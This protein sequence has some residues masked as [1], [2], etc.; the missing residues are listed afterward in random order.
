MTKPTAYDMLRAVVDPLRLAVAGAAVAGPVSIDAVARETGASKKEVARAVGDLRAVGILDEDGMVDRDALRTIG[1]ELP[2][3]PGA[4]G[5]PIDGPWTPEEAQMLG[6][7]FDG[8]RLVELPQ[9]RTKRR[10]VLEHITQR[11]EP[12]RRYPE[13][14]V[15]FMIQL[16]YPD[17]AAIRRY[18]VDEGFLD[19]ADGAYWRIGGRYDVAA[20][21]TPAEPEAGPHVLA[22]SIDG[23]ELRPWDWHMIDSLVAA[24]NDPRINRYMGDAFPHP[25]THD[26][27]ESWIEIA[28]KDAPPTQ[29]AI[30]RNGVLVGGLGGFPFRG[31]NTGAME[32][33]W[34]LNPEYWGQGITSAAVQALV[35]EF[36]GQREY[37]R[38]WAPVMKPNVA[39]ARVAEKAG[40]RL[41]GIAESAY[42]KQG[43]RLD[44]LNYAIT[45]AQWRSGP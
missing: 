1:R 14:D 37:M 22:T 26:A 42:L 19:R 15:N 28:S 25:Y 9:N 4:S 43:V 2:R 8:D 7:F 10:L 39:S 27:A 35:D 41:E 18:L 34:W 12:G 11:F 6:R 44:Q 45:R 21:G 23:V 30:H 17:Y 20:D 32:I 40:L 36:L 3:S 5:E 38:L 24:A 33:G 16:I 31:E 13:R 29:Y